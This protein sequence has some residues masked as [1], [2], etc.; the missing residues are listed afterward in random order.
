MILVV[1]PFP[2]GEDAEMSFPDSFLTSTPSTASTK[3]LAGKSSADGEE[4]ELCKKGWRKRILRFTTKQ[5]SE[6]RS[7]REQSRVLRRLASLGDLAEGE[8]QGVEMKRNEK[9]DQQFISCKEQKKLR[10]LASMG[11]LFASGAPERA[12]EAP[13]RS[14]RSP[15]RFLGAPERVLGA[16]ERVL[17]AP[18]KVLGA[19]ERVGRQIR[20]RLA[21]S[22]DRLHSIIK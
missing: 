1:E 18:E 5:A 11:S 4:G 10:K 8:G 12:L 14:L 19:P 9:D 21:T 6:S 2:Q 20:R 13:E 16:P 7:A 17:R 15:E 3:P 22:R